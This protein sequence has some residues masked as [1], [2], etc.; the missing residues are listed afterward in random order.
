VLNKIDRVDEP[1]RAALARELPEAIQLSAL[2][3]V[4]VKRLRGIIV[5]HFEQGMDE[6]TLV[7]P[8]ARQS[9]LGKIREAAR[10]VKEDWDEAGARL[11]VRAPHDELEKLRS[12]LSE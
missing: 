6:A 12:L 11:I 7:V 2:N 4:D 9:A 5:E 1:T 3:P 10:V 8:Y